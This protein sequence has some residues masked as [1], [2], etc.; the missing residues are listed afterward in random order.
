MCQPRDF[1][2]R[3]LETDAELVQ[4]FLEGDALSFKEIEKRY[5]ERIYR[6]ISMGISN[7]N[8]DV[9][10]MVQQ[11]FLDI[12]RYWPKVS[13]VEEATFR[14]LLFKIAKCKIRNH[15]RKERTKKLTR[16]Y[17]IPE[18]AVDHPILDKLIAQEIVASFSD[19]EFKVW[20]LLHLKGKTYK[21]I[22]QAM[23]MSIGKVHY[24]VANMKQKIEKRLTK[25]E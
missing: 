5:R 11:T 9:D 7:S 15:I 23:R 8:G 24:L 20:E 21:E 1:E 6:F 18:R 17:N 19:Q 16:V 13:W 10:V 2:F 22:G 14:R 3:E 12:L 25:E 4:D